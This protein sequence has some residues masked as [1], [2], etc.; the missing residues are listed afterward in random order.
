MNTL[1][2][3]P[4][5][6]SW[7]QLCALL[8][9]QVK[10]Y[11]RHRHMGENSSVPEE[12][13]RELLASVQYTLEQAPFPG[14]DLEEALRSGQTVLEGRVQKAR[15][16]LSLVT[17][18]APG[19]QTECRWEALRCLDRYLE[20]YDH[21]HLAHLGPETLFY[22]LPIPVPQG[23]RGMEEA[24]FFLNCLWQENQIMAA[25]EELGTEDLW[26]ILSRDVICVCLNQ[27]EQLI[28]N[29]LGKALLCSLSGGFLFRE[30]DHEKLPELLGSRSLSATLD[31]A[32]VR[33]CERLSLPDPST[34][35][36]I[37]T[38]ARQ[39]RPRLQGAMKSRDLR[40]IFL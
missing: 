14:Q 18:T 13:A 31:D 35:A 40:N 12:L 3:K 23:L 34:A 15:S 36:Y 24:L 7:V 39:L 28:I 32:A 21:L 16:A 1:P 33:L 22:P 29:G 20:G 19:W 37:H 9:N 30:A 38:A 5:R 11:H 4:E 25:A 8:E 17:A 6:R 27:C 10:S 2:Q 26:E